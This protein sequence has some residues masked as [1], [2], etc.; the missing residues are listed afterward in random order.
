M[1]VKNTGG[2]YIPLGHDGLEPG[3]L[4]EI[5]DAICYT[6]RAQNLRREV[7]GP[8]VMPFTEDEV[9]QDVA[10]APLEEQPVPEPV[11]TKEEAAAEAVKPPLVDKSPADSKKAEPSPKRDKKVSKK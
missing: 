1:L 4:K 11:P 2:I 6:E 7:G 9:V 3:E 10:P 5:A 8:L